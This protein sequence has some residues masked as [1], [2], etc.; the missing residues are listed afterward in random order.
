[1]PANS[2][3][4]PTAT[5]AATTRTKIRFADAIVLVNLC[6]ARATPSS[7]PERRSCVSARPARVMAARGATVVFVPTNNWLPSDRS[8]HRG[9]TAISPAHPAGV[10]GGGSGKLHLVSALGAGCKT[11][12]TNDRRLPTV[13]GLRV[14]KLSSYQPD[15]A[16]PTPST[17][18]VTATTN[19]APT[20]VRTLGSDTRPRQRT[21]R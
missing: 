7:C 13:P 12:L 6:G 10:R 14:I 18:A 1:M 20:I 5:S 3:T 21:S 2:T 17:I 16:H 19:V 8:L 4:T 11:F 15:Q 9:R